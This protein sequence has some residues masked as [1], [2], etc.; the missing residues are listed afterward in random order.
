MIVALVGVFAS[1][2]PRAWDVVEPFPPPGSDWGTTSCTRTRSKRGRRLAP[3]NPYGVG[4]TR[5]LG[6]YPGVGAVVRQLADPGRSLVASRSR[7]ALVVA[8]ALTPLAVYAAAAALW[9]IGAGLLAAA[10]YAVAPIHLEPLYWHGLATTL[11]LL[12]LLLAVLALA[13]MYRGR[14]DRDMIGLLG[15]SLAGV[16]V[17][18]SV[19]RGV[20]A[21][22]SSR[23]CCSPTSSAGSS[24]ARPRA[25][26]RDGMARPVLAGGASDASWVPE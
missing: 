8:V 7:A 18:H 11:G 6:S 24:P 26:W 4:E 13:L 25:W 20:V 3:E 16:V 9:G 12:F 1:R 17:F 22:V 23:S 15:F 10:A 5:P 14:R 21:A 19:E 2:S